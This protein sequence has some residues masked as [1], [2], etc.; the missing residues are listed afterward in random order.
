MPGDAPPA[1]DEKTRTGL[2][3]NVLEMGNAG[4][5]GVGA[6]V[7]LLAVGEAED[8]EGGQQQGTDCQEANSAELLR[9]HG[10]VAGL[11]RVQERHPDKIAESKHEA[12]AVGGNVDGGQDGGLH[13]VGVEDVESLDDGD[14]DDAVGDEAVQAVL[15]G[16][17][18]AVDNDPA[19][20]AGPELHELL[21]V[22]LS[23]QGEGDAWV[24]L[25]ANV[26]V[27]DDVAR[28]AAC[29]QLTE[30]GVARLDAE[31]A[32]VDKGAKGVGDQDIGR[33]DLDV[34]VGDESPDRE[35]GALRIGPSGEKAKGASARR[36]SYAN[37]QL[38]VV[39]P[40]FLG[41]H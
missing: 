12:E 9:V 39:S 25:A 29:R 37:S 7:V 31:A 10:E 33:Q 20:Q 1:R 21:D 38:C 15:L 35:L 2:G 41:P 19:E 8:G 18:G 16:D 6:E 28:V 14:E 40:I 3:L 32:N 4:V 13:D 5:V 34:V 17:E 27:V 23:D 30:L 24:E 36:E 22:N 26:P 11:L